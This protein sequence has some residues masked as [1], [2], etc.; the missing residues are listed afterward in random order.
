MMLFQRQMLHTYSTAWLDYNEWC[1]SK[2]LQGGGLFQGTF[3]ALAG[4]T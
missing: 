2:A 3:Q 1:V 4:R